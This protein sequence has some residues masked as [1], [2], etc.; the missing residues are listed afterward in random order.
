MFINLGRFLLASTLLT[1]FALPASASI[2]ASATYTD[3]ELSPGLFQYNL[4]L[5]NT[6]TTTIGT[7]WFSWIPGRGF[8][9]VTPTNVLSP[10]DWGDVLTNG[11]DA[12]R[13]TTSTLLAAGASVTGFTFDSTETPAQL[14]GPFAG[15]GLGTGDPVDTAFVYIAAPLAD[16]GFQLVAAAAKNAPVPEPSPLA[17]LATLMLGFA[18]LAARRRSK[19]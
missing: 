14:A 9:S 4:T 10:A 1:L 18:A 8:L 13:W 19:G 2:S 17:I 3:V 15:P 11:G 5:N 12:I 16:P 7:F 6:G